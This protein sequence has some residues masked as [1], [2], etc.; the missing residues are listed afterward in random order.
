[1]SF[2]VPDRV[3]WLGIGAGIYAL[4]RAVS[5]GLHDV[6]NLTEVAPAPDSPRAVAQGTE[7]DI[8]LPSLQVLATQHPN[9][10]IRKAATSIVTTRVLNDPSTIRRILAD[11]K[12]PDGAPDQRAARN[13]IQLI[14]STNGVDLEDWDE[15]HNEDDAAAAFEV[16]FDATGRG[17]GRSRSTADMRREMANRYWAVEHVEGDDWDD[18]SDDNSH[19]ADVTSDDGND[20]QDLTITGHVVT[21]NNDS[22]AQPSRR[23]GEFDAFVEADVSALFEDL[24]RPDSSPDGVEAAYG[25]TAAAP[26]SVLHEDGDTAPIW[27]RHRLSES[28]RAHGLRERR[29]GDTSHVVE[30]VPRPHGRRHLRTRSSRENEEEVARRR[31]RREAVVVNDGDRPISQDDII[32]RPLQRRSY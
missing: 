20:D 26:N 22:E 2:T 25:T 8:P 31:V 4:V 30:D 17:G 14:R 28:R 6:Y 21:E 23:G 11:Y 24:G 13:A 10:E 32:Q 27:D 7:D 18:A 1:M 5:Y 9:L 3:L 12:K 16:G 29:R 19:A 15:E